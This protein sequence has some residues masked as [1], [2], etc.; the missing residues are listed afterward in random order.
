MH[1]HIQEKVPVENLQIYRQNERGQW[2]RV[3]KSLEYEI[4]HISKDYRILKSSRYPTHIIW[5]DFNGYPSYPIG[6]FN[7]ET[8]RDL[9][10]RI[11][12]NSNENQTVKLTHESYFRRNMLSADLKKQILRTQ[13]LSKILR[14]GRDRLYSEEVKHIITKNENFVSLF[15]TSTNTETFLTD[16]S[17]R[18]LLSGKWPENLD[19]KLFTQD[20]GMIL[21]VETNKLSPG[22]FFELIVNDF[23][24]N[25]K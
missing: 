18:Q 16:V 13:N 6:F 22:V 23:L 24:Q 17:F 10:F 8:S 2:I 25:Q 1:E 3:G 15:N 14:E 12:E 20:L 21:N 11:I 7:C 19:H 9:A 5:V 4:T